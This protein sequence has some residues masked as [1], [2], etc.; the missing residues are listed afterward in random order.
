LF[1]KARTSLI[2]SEKILNI[3]RSKSE[4]SRIKYSE[5]LHHQLE[6]E[7]CPKAALAIARFD[8][9]LRKPKD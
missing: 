7:E 5:K 4:K 9:G 8:F 2:G 6:N 1:S 3:I